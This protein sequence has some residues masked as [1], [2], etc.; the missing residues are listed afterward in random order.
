[1]PQGRWGGAPQG[2]AV[3]QTRSANRVG[4]GCRDTSA[5]AVRRT[6][7]LP[8]DRLLRTTYYTA[9]ELARELGIHRTTV[10]RMA[11][12][13]DLPA[14]LRVGRICRWR[15][16]DIEAWRQQNTTALPRT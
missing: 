15:P 2:A 11:A 8:E 14:P 5:S 7:H 16:E 4:G 12:R 6:T 10:W 9:E 1:M 13:G 3:G